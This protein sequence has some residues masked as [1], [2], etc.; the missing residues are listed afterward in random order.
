VRRFLVPRGAAALAWAALAVF[1]LYGSISPFARDAQSTE[2]SPGISVPDITQNVLLYVP[3][4]VFGVWTLRRK[5]STRIALWARITAIA[6]VYSTSMELLQLGS[7][8]RIASPLDVFANVLGAWGG[9]MASAPIE[10]AFGIAAHFVRPTG[11][12]TA[13]ARYVLAAVLAAIVLAAWYPFDVTL[14]VSTLSERTREVRRDPWLWPGM[15]ELWGQGARFFVL[16]AVLTACLPGL[17]RRA[18]PVAFLAAVAIA[19]VIDLGQLG[20]GSDPVG[21]AVLVSQAAGAGAGAMCVLTL[22]RRTP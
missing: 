12:L 19:V 13:P 8:P 6:A 20:M 5:T 1:V 15:A 4:G 2:A 22:A 18:A 10:R 3:F 21:G 11:L 16:A 9:A 17:S 7:A 14:D